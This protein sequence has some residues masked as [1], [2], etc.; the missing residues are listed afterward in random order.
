MVSEA[1]D[2]SEKTS[3]QKIQNLFQVYFFHS[4]QNLDE[5]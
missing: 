2:Q 1:H 5:T 3:P 4:Q